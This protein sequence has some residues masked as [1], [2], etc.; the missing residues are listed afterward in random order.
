MS[1]GV[2]TQWAERLEVHGALCPEHCRTAARQQWGTGRPHLLVLSALLLA[3]L[4]DDVAACEDDRRRIEPQQLLLDLLVVRALL[5]SSQVKSRHVT[6]SQGRSFGRTVRPA[7]RH[8]IMMMCH[9][10]RPTH[11]HGC[12]V[13][14]TISVRV[15]VRIMAWQMPR[16][17][18]EDDPRR[19]EADEELGALHVE[20]GAVEALADL[21]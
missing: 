3:L 13:V 2:S 11:G 17:L 8:A 21:G 7:G 14:R 10:M 18:P 20:R 6:S 9:S 19:G 15:C 16:D 5:R 4:L 1:E 12:Y